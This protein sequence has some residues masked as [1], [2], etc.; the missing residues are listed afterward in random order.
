M[1]PIIGAM[2]TVYPLMNVRKLVAF[3]STS[4]GTQSQPPMKAHKKEPLGIS[5]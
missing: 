3:A 1:I 2:N 4:H 5:T